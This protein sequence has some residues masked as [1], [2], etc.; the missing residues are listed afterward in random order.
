MRWCW[1]FFFV[2]RYLFLLVCNLKYLVLMLYDLVGVGNWKMGRMEEVNVLMVSIRNKN[3]FVRF[4]C[5]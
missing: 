3:N 4:L 2:L 1:F 5:V